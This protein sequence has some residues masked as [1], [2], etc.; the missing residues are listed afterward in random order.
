MRTIG[1][2]LAADPRNT[3]LAAIEWAGSAAV[4]DAVVVG[5]DDDHLLAACRSADRVGVDCPLGWPVPFTG[6]VGD[7]A[8]RRAP[9]VDWTDPRW[10]RQLALRDTDL[11]C[12]EVTRRRT[13]RGVRP[14]S[15]SADLLGHVSMR[16]AVLE[17]RLRESGAVVDRTGTTGLVV[18]VYPAA[19]LALWGVAGASY[20]G[21]ARRASLSAAVKR[22]ASAAPWLRWP[23][24]AAAKCATSDHAFDAVVSAL[25]ARA[26][27]LGCAT[28]P[29]GAAQHARATVEG[30]IA[31]PTV[32][33][34]ELP[35]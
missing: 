7:H 27:A 3:G 25:A 30:W 29:A 8:A 16:W 1:I 6:F 10:R 28:R 13:G 31:L 11:T 12:I 23:A 34:D 32:P 22:L 9:A 21:A 24:D 5:Q 14:L 19:V 17:N 20:K 18:E 2:D 26:A 15:V 35:R 33:L 4:V